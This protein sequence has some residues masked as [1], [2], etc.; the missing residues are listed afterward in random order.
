MVRPGIPARVGLIEPVNKGRGGV[1]FYECV[2]AAFANNH[3]TFHDELSS[4]DKM[5]SASR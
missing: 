4:G 3:L 1:G 5:C 2:F